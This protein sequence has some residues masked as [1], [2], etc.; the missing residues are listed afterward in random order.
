MLPEIEILEPIV[1][2]NPEV[3]PIVTPDI[4]ENDPYD[5]PIPLITPNPKAIN[6]L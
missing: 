6:L 2:P 5:V 4:E 3:Y 1:I